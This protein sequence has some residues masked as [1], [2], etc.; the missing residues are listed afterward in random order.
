MKIRAMAVAAFVAAAG[1]ASFAAPAHAWEC[2]KDLTRPYYVNGST[3][4]CLPDLNCETC[5]GVAE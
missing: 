1:A 4:V 3:K 2:P 5:F